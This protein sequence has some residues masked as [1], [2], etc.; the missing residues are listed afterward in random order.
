M[1]EEIMKTR[2]VFGLFAALVLLVGQV[3]AK[4][5]PQHSEETVTGTSQGNH[6]LDCL[7]IRPWG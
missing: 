1:K 3:S 5:P 7:V 2:V 6:E 4:P